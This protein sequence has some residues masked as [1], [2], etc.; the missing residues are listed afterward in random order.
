MELTISHRWNTATKISFRFFFLY[1]VLYALPFPLG[2]FPFTDFV[3]EFYNKLWMSP[4]ALAGK[5][6][7]AL[8]YEITV[9][10]NGSG[11]T[12]YNYVQVFLF[13]VIAL[14]GTIVWSVVDR[15]RSNYEKLLY[16]FIIFLRY[17]LGLILLGYGFVKVIKTQFPFPSISRLMKSYGESSPMGLLWTFMG[18]STAYNIFTGLG[19]VL[20]G[21]F[22]F[23][24]RTK[25]LGALIA[26]AVMS[27]VVVLNFAYDVPVKLFSTHLLAVAILLIVPDIHR[28]I[29]FF[30]LNKQ[31]QPTP[32]Q[33]V[34]SNERTKTIYWIT[35][36]AFIVF[37]L[38]MN[39]VQG[40]DMQKQWGDA[41]PTPPLYGVYDVETFV[42][43]GD[44]IPSVQ[45]E[46]RRWK[47]IIIDKKERGTIQYMDGA[48]VPWKLSADTISHT[49]KG[50][51]YDS[52][53]VYRFVYAYENNKIMLKGTFHSDSVKVSLL[54]MPPEKLLL[55]NRG[56]RWVNE[57]PNNQ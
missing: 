5:Q 18:Y 31:V 52:T 56:F 27:N 44:T 25:V 28:L 7:F 45:N 47:K 30:V 6:I 55:V 40:L 39:V 20:G 51:S 3:W 22:L 32:L 49:L 8:D 35:K 19:E 21:F 42:I 33:P 1:F 36:G 43:N 37:L 53:N 38:T 2:W 15:K 17:Y 12:T 23:F 10:P 48:S 4:I 9:M 16:W 11:D 57:F 13:A 24:K 50:S 54:P 46:T 34:Y 14:A 41:V 29:N 26:I